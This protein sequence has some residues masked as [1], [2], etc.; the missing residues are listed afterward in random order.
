[1][2][3]FQILSFTFNMIS[4]N[5]YNPHFKNC[6]ESTI[7][8]KGVTESFRSVGKET[9]NYCLFNLKI[10]SH[11]AIFYTRELYGHLKKYEKSFKID[12]FKNPFTILWT[13]KILNSLEI[14]PF[15]KYIYNLSKINSSYFTKWVI[16][17]WD[18]GV[19]I[20][21]FQVPGKGL[22]LQVFS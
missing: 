15:A 5:S 9:R 6:L 12:L 18:L 11:F 17:S 3:K 14:A 10:F 7:N 4:T 1:M 16:T 8:F 13:E 21:V 2:I 19:R 20:N 22:T